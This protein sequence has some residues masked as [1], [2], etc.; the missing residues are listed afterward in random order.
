MGVILKEN[1]FRKKPLCQISYKICIII[2]TLQIQRYIIT[3]RPTYFFIFLSTKNE[4]DLVWKSKCA[5]NVFHLKS[6]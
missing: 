4:I 6:I 2:V 1:M 5:R 3:T